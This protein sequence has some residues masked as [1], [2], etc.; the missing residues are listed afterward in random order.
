MLLKFFD[1]LIPELMLIVARSFDT[2][3]HLLRMNP[4]DMLQLGKSA[5]DFHTLAQK[6]GVAFFKVGIY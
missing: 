1:A 4:L 3:Y 5:F 2:F 6:I